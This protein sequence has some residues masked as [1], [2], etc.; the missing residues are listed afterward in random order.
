MPFRDVR[1][2]K[3]KVQTNVSR[4][5][6]NHKSLQYLFLC[7]HRLSINNNIILLKM[8]DD[9]DDDDDDDNNNNNNPKL[10]IVHGAGHTLPEYKPH[11]ALQFY[12]RWLK[13]LT[14]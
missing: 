7:A 6:I 11:E 1:F 10:Y 3:Y 14:I 12:S 4:V 8:D 2:L 13:G 9:D 5:F